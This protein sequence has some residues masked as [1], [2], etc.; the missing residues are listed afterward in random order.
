MPFK[1]RG[2]VIM[3][4]RVVFHTKRYGN[5]PMGTPLTG[6]QMQGDDF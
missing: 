3:P 5:F 1:T 4:H 2:P 6:T